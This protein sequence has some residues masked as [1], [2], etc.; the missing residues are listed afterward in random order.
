MAMTTCE[1]CKKPIS[2]SA[3]TCPHCGFEQPKEASR[4]KIGFVGLVLIM[5]LYGIANQ[6]PEKPVQAKTPAEIQKERQFQQVV[7]AARKLKAA[8]KNPASFELV[9]ALVMAGPTIC[10]TYRST[11]SF[12]AVVTERYTLNDKVSTTS[13]AAWNK[14]CGGKTGDDYSYAKRAI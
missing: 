3:K 5:I 12:N 4:L 11:N 1:E 6:E 2:G 10:M 8:M 7:Q 9:S 14:H 13:T